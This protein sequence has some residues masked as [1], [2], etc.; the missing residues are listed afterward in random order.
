MQAV[1]TGVS[2][3]RNRNEPNHVIKEAMRAE[4]LGLNSEQMTEVSGKVAI[5]PSC[6]EIMQLLGVIEKI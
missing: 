6:A 5:E 3:T 2:S 4:R 1:S